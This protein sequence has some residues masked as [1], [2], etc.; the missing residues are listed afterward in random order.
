MKYLICFILILI[1]ILILVLLGYRENFTNNETINFIHIPK[2]AG[3]SIKELCNDKLKYNEH[4]TNVFNPTLNNQLVILRNPVDRFVSAVKYCLYN[5]KYNSRQQKKT[6]ELLL[7]NNINTPDKFIN[8]W[9][10]KNHPKHEILMEEIYNKSHKID[11]KKIKYKWTY[12]PQLAWFNKPKYIL[13]M[14]NLDK[15]LK[16]IFNDLNMPYNLK[17]QNTTKKEN[18]TISNEN[19]V[20]INNFYKEDWVLY[21]KYKNIPFKNR[22]T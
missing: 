16:Y 8:I 21:N 11:N 20:W 12:T 15:E 4:G 5:S 19:L 7:K 6:V 9:K 22:I 10:N 13:I 2:N 17:K 3:T 18:L 1:I 14:D